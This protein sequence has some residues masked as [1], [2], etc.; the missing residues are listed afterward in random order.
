VSFW[1]NSP[2]DGNGRNEILYQNT[3]F[4]GKIPSGLLLYISYQTGFK[5]IE[6]SSQLKL[7]FLV[8]VEEN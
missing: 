5:N 7:A 8:Q 2:E 3:E 1:L 6:T 4:L